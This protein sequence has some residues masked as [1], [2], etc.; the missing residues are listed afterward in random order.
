MG[1]SSLASLPSFPHL[2]SHI[3]SVSDAKNPSIIG[4]SGIIVHET[5]NAF[6][7]VTRKD[8]TKRK[9]FGVMLSS[10]YPF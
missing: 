8:E 6:R 10:A 4:C 9:P 2:I 5:E 7:V 3:F 1:L